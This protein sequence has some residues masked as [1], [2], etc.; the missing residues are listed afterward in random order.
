MTQIVSDMEMA[1]ILADIADSQVPA[2]WPIKSP[3]RPRDDDGLTTEIPAIEPALEKYKAYKGRKS[4][5][6][7][8]TTLET[9]RANCKQ[10]L[11]VLREHAKNFTCP[12]G[13][14][15]RPK[16]HVR[17]D[18]EFQTAPDQISH[19]A[20]TDMLALMIKQQEKNLAADNQAIKDQQQL[21][22]NLYP[23]DKHSSQISRFQTANK[24]RPRPRPRPQKTHDVQQ[25]CNFASMQAQ[26]SELQKIFCQFNESVNAIKIDLNLTFLCLSLTLDKTF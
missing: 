3:K 17:F 19:R 8:L 7:R 25:T 15:Y 12:F 18:R 2:L 4:I 21:L 1:A 13:L 9:R 24:A 14:L 23:T 22:Q 10:P 5:W 6:N 11:Q 26:L 20:H 16:P